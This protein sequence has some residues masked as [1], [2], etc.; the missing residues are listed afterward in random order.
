MYLSLKILAAMKYTHYIYDHSFSSLNIL[1]RV[2]IVLKTAVKSNL[3]GERFI[4]F[5]LQSL[6]EVK[7]GTQSQNLEA[8][9]KAEAVDCEKNTMTKATLRR[10]YLV[11]DLLTFQRVIP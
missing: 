8:G 1:D 3:G 4:S 6:R 2:S 5:I 11:G 10:K 7:T 9:A